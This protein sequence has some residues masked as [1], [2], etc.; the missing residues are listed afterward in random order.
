MGAYNTIFIGPA[1]LQP[2]PEGYE[3]E[4]LEYERYPITR[5][6]VKNVWSTEQQ[7]HE[8]GIELQMTHR[9][10]TLIN[11]LFQGLI[12]APQLVVYLRRISELK[13]G[14]LA[15]IAVASFYAGCQIPGSV[16]L[17]PGT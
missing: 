11:A 12:A 5:W 16:P 9:I 4:E 1:I 2:T 13:N 8:L 15:M 6:W 10:I 3:P 14:R 17:L 7:V